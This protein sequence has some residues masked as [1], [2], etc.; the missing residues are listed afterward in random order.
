V[1]KKQ[2]LNDAKAELSKQIF[3]TKDSTGKSNSL[4]SS[5]KKATET[6]KNTFGNL[7]KKKKATNSSTDSTNK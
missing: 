6:L 1:V 3:G 7:L 2:V 4:D 5:K